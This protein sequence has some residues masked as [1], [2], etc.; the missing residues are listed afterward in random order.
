MVGAV[1]KN[2]LKS[3]DFSAKGLTKAVTKA[4]SKQR[5]KA[6]LE[7]KIR[8][9]EIQKQKNF[10][11]QDKVGQQKAT[12]DANK[13]ASAELKQ[14]TSESTKMSVKEQMDLLQQVFY[15]RLGQGIGGEF[16]CENKKQQRHSAYPVELS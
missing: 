13:N 14:P 15:E 5:K 8:E 9:Q 2:L 7:E 16:I 4:T 11:F 1:A 6:I 10:V 3:G 12:V